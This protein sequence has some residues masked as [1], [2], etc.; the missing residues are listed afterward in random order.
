LWRP[1]SFCVDDGH[2]FCSVEQVKEEVKDICHIIEQFY[3]R[4]GMYG[5]HWVSL[6]VRDYSAPEKYIGDPNDWDR[7]EELLGE[8][9]DELGLNATRMEGEA[10][11][12]GPKLD[13][14]FRDSHGND[15]QLA[16]VQLDFAMPKRFG[17]S[18]ID[19]GGESKQP[20]IIHRAILGSYE[21]FIA[22][23]LEQFK[24][25]L[26]L[27]LAPEQV[28]ILPISEKYSEYSEQI[29]AKILQAGDSVGLDIRVEID[30]RP[31]RVQAKI[32]SA[33]E[34]HIPYSLICG[35]RELENNSLSVRHFNSDIGE[36]NADE[37]VGGLIRKVKE[38]AE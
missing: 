17:I 9:S 32:K 38:R 16:T 10:A 3:S 28:R 31:E 13:F 36:F 23:L 27:W 1:V 19:S 26:P 14:M 33:S 29:R 21:R 18:Y 6:S 25:K 2:T 4:L 30:N 24:D 15:R 8:V 7:C 12:Y 20:V 22:L 34:L 37:F 5:N 35:E 11:L